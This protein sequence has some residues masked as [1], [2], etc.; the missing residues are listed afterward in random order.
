MIIIE[1]NY[2]LLLEATKRHSANE[3]ECVIPEADLMNHFGITDADLEE[4]EDLEIE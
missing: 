3:G 4:A 1:E 2:N